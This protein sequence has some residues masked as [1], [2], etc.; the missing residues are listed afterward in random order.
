G[1]SSEVI[2]AA[3]PTV[4]V[5]IK[6]TQI[7]ECAGAGVTASTSG[8]LVLGDFDHVSIWGGSSGIAA[9]NAAHLNVHNSTIFATTIAINNNGGGGSAVSVFN[10]VLANNSTAVQSIAGGNVGVSSN[11]IIGSSPVY[12][13]N[14]GTISTG[15]DN[16]SILN[17]AIGATNGPAISKI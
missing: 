16:I 14:G 7:H 1:S 5:T 11:T 12:N 9:G 17:G 4:F 10:N 8:G 6:D 2:I 15:N 3:S 13:T